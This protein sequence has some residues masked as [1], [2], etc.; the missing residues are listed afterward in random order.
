[1]TSELQV[2]AVI[3]TRD[4]LTWLKQAVEALRLQSRQVDK[5]IVVDNN[6]SDGTSEWLSLQSDVIVY[7]QENLGSSGGQWRGLREA[8]DAGFDWV[9]C[10]DDDTIPEPGALQAMLSTD[11]ARCKETGFLCSYVK[12]RDDSPHVMNIPATVDRVK[13]YTELSSVETRDSKVLPVLN[14]SFVSVMVA[15]RAIAEVG[16]PLKDM[17]IWGDDVEY[18]S[19]IGEHFKG[20]QILDSV[21]LHD[22]AENTGVDIN[23]LSDKTLFKFKY[24]FRN[25]IFLKLQKKSALGR[26]VG[27]SRYVPRHLLQMWGRV[28]VRNYP[29]VSRYI[30]W[31][32]VFRPVP[33][34]PERDAA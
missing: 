7:W 34:I 8:F 19:R 29:E 9:W 27:A 6:S 21:V 5:I 12:W 15:R 10:M 23:L 18:T 33:D 17:F 3:V 28:S 4:R 1:M 2:A 20:Y 14:C 11:A 31:G 22:T 25:K 24:Y 26:I 13:S 32:A 30:F 16:L